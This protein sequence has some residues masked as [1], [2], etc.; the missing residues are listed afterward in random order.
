[1]KSVCSAKT[2]DELRIITKSTKLIAL[3]QLPPTSHVIRAHIKRAYLDIQNDV[4]LF[5]SPNL[6]PLDFLL[7][8]V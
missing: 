2:F 3:D 1:M 6:D 7:E 8:A 5:D 4:S